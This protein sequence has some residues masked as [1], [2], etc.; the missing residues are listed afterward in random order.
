MGFKGTP[1]PT[2]PPCVCFFVALQR[3]SCDINSLTQ[4]AQKLTQG[5]PC[6]QGC[7][8]LLASASLFILDIPK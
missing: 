4:S 2:G 6:K 3:A 7:F 5:S 1:P 8:K